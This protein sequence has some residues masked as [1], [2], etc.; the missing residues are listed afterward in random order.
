MVEIKFMLFCK[1]RCSLYGEIQFNLITQSLSMKRFFFSF[2]IESSF[3]IAEYT[4]LKR[5]L[6]ENLQKKDG[7]K[8][9][10]CCGENSWTLGAETLLAILF[11][12]QKYIDQ[13]L[14]FNSN[15]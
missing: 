2:R 4:K 3:K 7:Y 11:D 6:E 12:V 9:C 14:T 8:Q 13:L 1:K 5:T 10:R 15:Q